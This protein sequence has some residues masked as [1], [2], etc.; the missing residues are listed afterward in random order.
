MAVYRKVIESGVL[1]DTSVMSREGDW[2]IGFGEQK[3]LV[4][5]AR[6][7]E[8]GSGSEEGG[9]GDG[10]EREIVDVEAEGASVQASLTL[11][12]GD[13]ATGTQGR[14]LKFLTEEL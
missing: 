11:T 9:V 6:I 13:V 8:V 2:E 10:A 4:G 3:T 7:E 5:E 12:S 1:S 14:K